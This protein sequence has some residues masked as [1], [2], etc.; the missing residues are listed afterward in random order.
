M[1]GTN[2]ILSVS[3]KNKINGKIQTIANKQFLRRNSALQIIR[4]HA[5]QFLLFQMVSFGYFKKIPESSEFLIT[6]VH[7]LMFA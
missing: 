7:S 4:S 2:T 6:N 1:R 3:L 5:N